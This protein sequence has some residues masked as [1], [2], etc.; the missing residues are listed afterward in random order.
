[1][2][3]TRKVRV[4][5]N[6]WRY[7][8]ETGFLRCTVIVL[9]S[10]VMEYVAGE[11]PNM[12]E[13]L[14][15]AR[16]YVSPEELSLPE[17]VITLEGMPAVVGHIW[18]S[19]T[20]RNTG[21]GNV[22]GT[23]YVI[24]SEVAE[25]AELYCDVLVTDPETV[26]RIMLSDGDEEKLVE[27]SSAFDAR[28]TWT[29]GIAAG[30]SHDGTFSE[31][32][33]NHIALLPT[34]CGRAGETVRI[35]NQKDEAK[36]EFTRIKLRSGGFARVANED[37]PALEADMKAADEEVKK[38]IDP[39]KLQETLD[40]LV[41]AKKERDDAQAKIDELEGSVAALREQLEDALSDTTVEAAAEQM[42]AEK[43]EAEQVLVANSLTMTPELKKL[44]GHPLRVAVVN[45]IRKASGRAELTA[46]QTGKEDFV[47]GMFGTIK[48]T[49]AVRAPH[50]SEA[51]QVQNSAVKQPVNAF[52][53][54]Y[55]KKEGGK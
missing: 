26:R 15:V 40:A 16:V 22:A 45:S 35:I 41:A 33:Y 46:E 25:V 8:P 18:Q 37:V 30:I 48:E 27:I 29:P 36:M 43:D 1:M 32:S 28:V 52:N 51:F 47:S 6:E 53:R 12:P 2:N 20:T 7:D 23:P 5:N 17:S 50:G 9:K 3:I 13:G 42:S 11:L 19:T 55:G 4:K 54:A 49:V 44:R 34:G 31:I 21:C 38:T 10:G 39:A 14:Q 24:H